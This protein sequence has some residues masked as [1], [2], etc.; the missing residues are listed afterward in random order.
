MWRTASVSPQSNQQ[1]T[2]I[3]S[4]ML[5][6]LLHSVT[7]VSV[8]PLGVVIIRLSIRGALFTHPCFWP[9]VK[10]GA[11]YFP[12]RAW[13]PEQSVVWPPEG[14]HALCCFNNR[15]A[16]WTKAFMEVKT[17]TFLLCYKLAQTR[18]KKGSHRNQFT[19]YDLG[20]ENKEVEVGSISSVLSVGR[21]GSVC[22]GIL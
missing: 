14:S 9:R 4:A 7:H 12:P 3:K 8:F 17:K 5:S 20:S 16:G 2:G 6:I 19:W 1:Q 11:A 13:R 22:K 18:N 21:S 10:E 15:R